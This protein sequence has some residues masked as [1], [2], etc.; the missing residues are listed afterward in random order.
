ALVE[1]SKL[2]GDPGTLAALALARRGK[3]EFVSRA[4][5]ALRPRDSHSADEAFHQWVQR[6]AEVF[7]SN[8]AAASRMT[9]PE[10]DSIESW[11][12][13]RAERVILCDPW[14]PLLDKLKLD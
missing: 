2:D 12:T 1:A 14:R 7:F 9:R 10:R 5:E 4:L 13:A 11:W 6:K 3:R 8:S